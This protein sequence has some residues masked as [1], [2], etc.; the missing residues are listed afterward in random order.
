MSK[1]IL[2]GRINLSY[3]IPEG[4]C[5][6]YIF[7]DPLHNFNVVCL[8]QRY[9]DN[10]VFSLND[11]YFSFDASFFYLV[12][13]SSGL[14]GSIVADPLYFYLNILIPSFDFQRLTKAYFSSSFYT[15]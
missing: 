4:S 14:C 7:T 10:F 8:I 6:S 15:G 11:S 13:S 12:P 3:C 1:F 5:F 9:K 2:K